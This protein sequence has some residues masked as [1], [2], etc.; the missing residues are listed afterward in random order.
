MA[1]LE[2]KKILTIETG[3][4]KQNIDGLTKSFVPLKQQI[5]ELREQLAQLENGTEEYNRVAKQLADTNQKQIEISEAMRYSNKDFG[6]TMSN[7]TKIS[8]GLVGG[9]NA[10]SASMVLLGGD[11]EDMQKSLMK[12]QGV[13]AIIQG[14]SALDTALKSVNG[15]KNAFSEVADTVEQTADVTGELVKEEVTLATTTQ[16]VNKAQQTQNTLNKTSKV[17]WKGV[18]TSIKSA[19]M[20]MK[21]FITSNP[22]LAA[23][24]A[25]IGVLAAGIS[26]LNKTLESNGRVA[27]EERDL[28]SD[29]NN[30]YQEQTI[31]LNV[32]QKTAKD[33]N[34]NIQE[35]KKAVEELNKIVPQYN[36]HI[37]ENTGLLVA[38][39]EAMESYLE[40]LK[41]KLQLEAYEG[42]IKEY[43]EKQVELEKEINDLETTGWWF[44]KARVADRRKEIRQLDE[45]IQRVYNNIAKLDISK[46]LNDNKPKTTTSTAKKIVKPIK[47]AIDDLKKQAGELWEIIY[48]A[49]AGKGQYLDGVKKVTDEIQKNLQKANLFEYITVD[50]NSV[51]KFTTILTDKLQSSIKTQDFS[52]FFNGFNNADIFKIDVFSDIETRSR[53]LVAALEKI[54]KEYNEKRSKRPNG[55][56]TAAE[57]NEYNK[58][59]EQLTNEINKLKLEEEAYKGI[60]NAVVEYRKESIESGDV[61]MEQYQNREK[62]IKLLELEK[63]YQ[64]DLRGGDMLADINRTIES[65]KVELEMLEDINKELENRLKILRLRAGNDQDFV[66]EIK[67]LEQTVL[68]NQVD[69]NRQKVQLD[70]DM[71]TRR[72]QMIEN[73]K[74][75]LDSMYLKESSELENKKLMRGG[76][77]SDYNLETDRLQIQINNL[78]KIRDVVKEM[79]DKMEIDEVEYNNRMLEIQREYDSLEIEMTKAKVDRKLAIHNTYFNALQNLSSSIGGILD[80]EMAKYD[81][82]SRQY[83][84]LAVAKGWIDTL[85]GSLSAFMSG[86]QSG[87]PWPYNLIL[88]GALGSSTFATG[89]MQI[90][91]IKSGGTSNALSSAASSVGQ[92]ETTV[93]QQQV[94]TMSNIRDQKVYVLEHDISQTQ[95]RVNVR[96]ANSRY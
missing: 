5:K 48:G 33:H 21:S 69:I 49:R 16:A 28:M 82:N 61:F 90:N 7:L 27:R 68:D 54:E 14:M 63:Q 57:T 22:L 60:K 58:R 30:Q 3:K 26:F 77:T 8:V 29:V 10:I 62:S 89:M 78:N 95:N 66:D 44:V 12:I 31:R 51:K 86:F 17:T 50:D 46:A 35:R 40:N 45:D 1:D 6:A 47:D 52:Q 96:E 80:Q 67:N 79:Y 11:S 24:A 19:A 93:Y 81:E 20:A 39:N 85:G 73:Y 2:K 84:E 25:V 43:L 4:S 65:E 72:T 56:L 74:A 94:E 76:G 34:Q 41:Q 36:A 13:M 88:A 64:K 42:K 55:E 87:I 92:Y 15:L 53:K 91:Q 83:R 32:L 9:I 23:L 70:A 18:T 37:D 38:N 75:E 59:K 71:Y